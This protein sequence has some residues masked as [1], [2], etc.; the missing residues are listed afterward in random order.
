MRVLGI[1]ASPRRVGNSE[2]V[3]KE[4]LAV[5][6]DT[7]E[8]G[9][10]NLNDLVIERCKACYACLPKEKRC[11]LN[12][13]LNF[14][15]DQLRAADKIIIAAPVYFLGQ[16][17]VLK[18]INDRL[19]SILNNGPEYFTAKQCVIV[20]PY[21]IKDWEGYARE[22]TMHFARF[23]GLQVSGTL[24]VKATLPGD[25]AEATSLA[26][27]KKL[28]KSL[29]D[30]TVVDFAEPDQ[31]YCPDCGSSLLQIQHKA[32]W[33]CVFCGAGGEWA[34][35]DGQFAITCVPRTR[36]RF[37]LAGMT[38]HGEL[39]TQAKN[40]FISNRKQVA[41]IQQQYKDPDYWLKPGST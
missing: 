14:F 2:I 35:A 13:D 8:K 18:Q 29:A 30:N 10:I 15:L 33:R 6:P 38:A 19:I 39:L 41:A 7:W 5:L 21:G 9:M 40:E 22:A 1:V 34:V 31:V 20:I 36:Q 27:V 11:I 32:K 3:V 17:T 26:A 4:M 16:H 24:L 25:A 28:A 37:S 23:L 12:D